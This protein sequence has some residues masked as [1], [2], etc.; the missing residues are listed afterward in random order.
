VDSRIVKVIE[1]ASILE[2]REVAQT[3]I[4]NLAS[5]EAIGRRPSGV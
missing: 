4:V 2:T 3:L 5:R 1:I